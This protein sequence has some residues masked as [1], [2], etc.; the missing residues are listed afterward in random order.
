MKVFNAT[1]STQTGDLNEKKSCLKILLPG[2]FF[3]KGLCS[4]WRNAVA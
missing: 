4:F 1:N 3:G 2:D